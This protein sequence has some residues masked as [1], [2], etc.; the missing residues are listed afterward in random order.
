MQLSMMAT[1]KRYSKF[2]ADFLTKGPGLRKPLRIRRLASADE[3]WLRSHKSQ[4]GFVMMTFGFGNGQNA[5]IDP[6]RQQPIGGGG[7]IKVYRSKPAL[8]V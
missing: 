5:P 3:R 1:A 8:R 7:T 2:V 4:M 6:G